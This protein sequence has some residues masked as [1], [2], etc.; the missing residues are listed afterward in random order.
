MVLAIR[1]DASAR[2]GT[3]HVMRCFAL[4][5]SWL[6]AGGTVHFVT[7]CE[8]AALAERL[9]FAGLHVSALRDESDW[10]AAEGAI[11]RARPAAL[12]LDG[13][14]FDSAYQR[15]A[16]EIVR[17]LLVIDDNAHL[18]YYCADLL[19]NQNIHAADLAYT[20]APGTKMLLGCRWALLRKE[21]RDWIGW[22]R[23]IP[24]VARKVLVT[25]G[26]SDPDNVTLRVIE[27][28]ERSTHRGYLQA[29]VV[30]GAANP[31]LALLERAVAAS[32]GIEL[33]SGGTD[34]AAVMAWADLAI[35]AGGTTCW[36]AAFFGLPALTLVIAENQE[37][38]TR[39]LERFG[40]TVNLG[41]YDK[42]SAAQIATALD[43]L[44]C[45][46]SARRQMSERGREL[47]DGNGAP[48]TV[49]AIK[50]SL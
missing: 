41:W 38:G 10:P 50:R 15:R 36:E 22:R 37:Q 7:R 20:V 29:I 14:Q 2:M 12:V 17:P 27:G 30:V 24:E 1:A 49:A 31:H 9:A 23:E 40:A 44:V 45:T 21:F 25:L 34:M 4:A 26:G 11:R 19:L 28:L 35:S 43:E 48:A 8:S 5:Q 3:G 6:D 18:P 32:P 13:Y 46:P 47:V 16:R 33:R 42:L 39:A